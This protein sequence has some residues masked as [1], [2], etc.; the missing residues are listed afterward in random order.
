M[1]IQE[2]KIN[3]LL[4]AKYVLV[5]DHLFMR[6]EYKINENQ[7]FCEDL[8]TMMVM[9]VEAKEIKKLSYLNINVKS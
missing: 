7:R 9:A 2:L 4:I 1:T 5:D 3:N 6:I 8:Y